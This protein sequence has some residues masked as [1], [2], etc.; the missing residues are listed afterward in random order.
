MKLRYVLPAALLALLPL[1]EPAGAQRNSASIRVDRFTGTFS[2]RYLAAR[3]AAADRDTTSASEFFRDA[4]RR[5]PRNMELVERAFLTYLADGQIDDAAPLAE[6]IIGVDPKNRFARLVL[7]VRAIKQRHF[8]TARLHIDRGR[9]EQTGDLTAVLLSA[10]T[11]Q[12]SGE[13]GPAILAVEGLQGQDWFQLFKL[14]HEGLIY[15]VAGDKAKAGQKLEAAYKLDTSSQRFV[16]AY[17]RWLARNKSVAEAETLYAAFAAKTA[18]GHPVATAAR[19]E[20]ARTK[21]LKPLIA[22]AEQGAAEV[23]YGLGSFLSRNGGGDLALVYLRLAVYLDPKS[24]V[25]LMALGDLF[26]QLKR[27][28]QAVVTYDRVPKDSPFKRNA[29]IQAALNLETLEKSDEARQRLTALANAYPKDIEVLTALGN[30]LRSRKQFAECAEAYEK[31]L[32][33]TGAPDVKFWTLYYFRGICYERSKQWPKAEA[34]FQ[35]ALKLQ[36]DHPHILNYLGYSWIDQGVKLNEALEMVKKAVAARPDDGYMVDSLGWAH[37]RLGQFQDAVTV[38]ER[39]VELKP[40]DP[41][42]NDHLGDAYW[43]VGR[44]L[45]ATFKW[46]QARDLKPEPDE[47][48]RIEKKLK[49]GLDA[50]EKEEKDANASKD[51]EVKPATPALPPEAKPGETTPGETKPGETKPMDAPAAKPMEA[52]PAETKPAD[53]APAAPATPQ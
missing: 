31:A 36:P 49:I 40:E 5:D 41:V 53:P 26:E 52:P 48:K 15:E 7:A 46:N 29:E 32:A 28:E 3:I 1:A 37:Y 39:A 10:W 42:I 38:M 34:D 14:I 11:L 51:A 43:R 20:I 9:S 27:S 23:L 6:R 22:T 24:G 33:E 25:A 16:D 2:G 13:T 19:E 12:G 44:E 35:T 45:E 4:L 8:K 17:G 50:V 21:T 18:A 30:V 47:L